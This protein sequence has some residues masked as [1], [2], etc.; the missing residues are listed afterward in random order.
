[1]RAPRLCLSSGGRC[2]VTAGGRFSYFARSVG[3]LAVT[4]TAGNGTVFRDGRIES[5]V[6]VGGA[7]LAL[8]CATPARAAICAEADVERLPPSFE[9]TDLC[10]AR[11][12]G[13]RLCFHLRQTL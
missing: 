12:R 10:R 3:R 8:D 6:L 1:M 9:L 7:A 4:S 2:P 5:G 11:S 13:F